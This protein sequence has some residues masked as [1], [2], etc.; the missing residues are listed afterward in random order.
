MTEKQRTLAKDITIS[1]KGLHTGLQVTM[2]IKPA[3][4][5]H[6]IRFM[7][8]DLEENPIVHAIVDNVVDTSRGTT[9]DQNGVRIG[10]MEHLLAALT[11]HRIDNSL[12]EIDA[13]EVP[14]LDGSSKPIFEAIAVVGTVEQD[15]ERKYSVLNRQEKRG[16]KENKSKEKGRSGRA[17]RHRRQ[18]QRRQ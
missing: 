5:N 1:G 14:I 9:L 17:W 7:R 18:R 10:T 2:V 15:A 13:P 11:G 4:A 12:I 3:P 6:G 8:I 16:G